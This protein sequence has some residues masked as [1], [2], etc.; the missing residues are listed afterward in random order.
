MKIKIKLIGGSLTSLGKWTNRAY[1]VQNVKQLRFKLRNKAS[2][3]IVRIK[4]HYLSIHIDKIRNNISTVFDFLYSLSCSD[5]LS[6]AAIVGCCLTK[7][8]KKLELS[9]MQPLPKV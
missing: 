7:I 9:N 8:Q 2:K 1:K 6:L 3:I 4:L 5:A